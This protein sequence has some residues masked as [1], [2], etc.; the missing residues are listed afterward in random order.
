M[1]RKYWP[2]IV[3]TAAMLHTIWGDTLAQAAAQHSKAA[4]GIS[5]VLAIFARW[6]ASPKQP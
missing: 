4:I 6:T 2:E 5:L 3:A 1:I